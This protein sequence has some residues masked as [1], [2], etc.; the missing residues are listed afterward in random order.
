M[1][2]LLTSYFFFYS[3]NP[4][5]NTTNWEAEAN[6]ACPTVVH[7]PPNTKYVQLAEQVL[8]TTPP[9]TIIQYPKSTTTTKLSTK[10]KTII[11]NLFFK[12]LENLDRDLQKLVNDE[13]RQDGIINATQ[14]QLNNT[15][16][17]NFNNTDIHGKSIFC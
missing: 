9:T 1:S 14:Q 4:S 11:K 6:Y 7:Q 5:S 13:V 3:I 2:Y 16:K 17:L 12:F 15:I 10:T 8:Q